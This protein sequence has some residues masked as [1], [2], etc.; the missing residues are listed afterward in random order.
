MS[1]CSGPHISL[2]KTLYETVLSM[3]ESKANAIQ[4]FL[5]SPTQYKIRSFDEKDLQRTG[6]YLRFANKKLYVHAPYIINL[7]SPDEEMVARAKQS[8]QTIL[9]TLAKVDSERTGTVLHIGA[10][11]TLQNVI[12]RINDLHISSPLFLENCAESCKFGK[13][14]NELWKLRE[15]IHSSNVGFCLDTCHCHSSKLCDMSNSESVVRM[16]EDLQSKQVIVHLNDSKTDYGS[17]LD[18]HAIVGFGKIWNYYQGESFESLIT[19]R[20][21]CKDHSFDIILET[22]SENIQSYELN[23]LQR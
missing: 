12:Q 2:G 18:R 10:K 14:M 8:L 23:I 9:D 15:G 11:G 17:G 19:L 7:A 22:P 3:Q 4:V 6:D 20:D 13:N 21:Y 1:C 16:F 5:G